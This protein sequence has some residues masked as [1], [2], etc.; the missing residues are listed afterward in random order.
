MLRQ[1]ESGSSAGA[2]RRY[3][4]RKESIFQLGASF[5]VAAGYTFEGPRRLPGTLTGPDFPIIRTGGIEHNGTLA[6]KEW[7]ADVHAIEDIRCA[8]PNRRSTQDDGGCYSKPHTTISYSRT[9]NEGQLLRK[10]LG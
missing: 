5:V 6:P 7:D 9:A 2:E 3:R 8:Y 1:V 4:E 10:L